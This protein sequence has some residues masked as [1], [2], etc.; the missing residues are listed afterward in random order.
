MADTNWLTALYI[1][2]G[3]LLLALCCAVL[4]L[5]WHWLARYVGFILRAPKWLVVV[6][7]I[8]FPPAFVAFLIGLIPYT[9]W[10]EKEDKKFWKEFMEFF[11]EQYP[12]SEHIKGDEKTRRQI[13]TKRRQ[14]GYDKLSR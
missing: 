6:C 1:A 13:A 5:A 8:L 9:I 4:F 12:P 2:G 7:F 10:V 14:L 11:W 3:L